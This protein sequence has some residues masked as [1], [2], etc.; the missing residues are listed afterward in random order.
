MMD[1]HKKTKNTILMITHDP[2]VATRADIS[3]RVV[4]KKLRKLSNL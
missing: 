1:L 3:Y 2:D 4:Q